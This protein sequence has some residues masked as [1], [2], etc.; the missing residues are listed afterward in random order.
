MFRDLISSRNLFGLEVWRSR[1]PRVRHLL[2]RVSTS[3]SVT[4]REDL[5]DVLMPVRVSGVRPETPGR[6]PPLT[7][8]SL[9]FPNTEGTLR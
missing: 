9:V 4:V 5:G 3:S 1:C 6:F 2:Y 7:S 8:L